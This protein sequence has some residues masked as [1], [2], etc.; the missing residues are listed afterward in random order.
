MLGER[1]PL[2]TVWNF[3]TLVG[4]GHQGK[5]NVQ[6]QF[7]LDISGP[8]VFDFLVFKKFFFSFQPILAQ[9]SESQTQQVET[10]LRDRIN[11]LLIFEIAGLRDVENDVPKT[12][13]EYILHTTPRVL[14]LEKASQFD[15]YPFP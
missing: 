12:I 11:K 14:S 10:Q 2:F 15:S 13:F 3:E 6:F 4:E 1:H 8:F 5:K 9:R 7:A